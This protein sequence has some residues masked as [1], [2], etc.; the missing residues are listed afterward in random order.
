MNASDPTG[1]YVMQGWLFVNSPDFW[2][3]SAVEAYLGGVPDSRMLILDLFTEAQPAWQ[4]LNSYYG[5][6]WIWC[7]LQVRKRWTGRGE[8][9]TQA[10][11]ELR[12][13]RTPM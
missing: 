1:T 9:E 8:N 12:V 3:P 2:T 5:K 13:S 10:R 11:Q 6:P 4:R 7:Q